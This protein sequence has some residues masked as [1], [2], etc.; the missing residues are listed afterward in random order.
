MKGLNADD[1]AN[2]T[3]VEA[4]ETITPAEVVET[5][6]VVTPPAEVVTT[7]VEVVAPTD[8]TKEK[9]FFE[10]LQEKEVTPPEMVVAPDVKVKELESLLEKANSK[11]KSYEESPIGK[12]AEMVNGEYD[13]TKVDIRKIAKD[14]AGEDYSKYDIKDLIKIEIKK[15][16]PNISDEKLEEGVEARFNKLDDWEIDG[17]KEKIAEKLSA[18]QTPSEV[19][20]QLQKIQQ[21]QLDASKVNPQEYMN[22]VV[23]KGLKEISDKF[24]AYGEQ[25]VGQEFNGYKATK[26]DADAI[27]SLFE[28]DSKNYDVDKG[29]LNN[30]KIV[31]YDKYA[32]AREQAGYERGLK[33]ATNSNP[34]ITDGN[35]VIVSRDDKKGLAGATADSFREA[36]TEQ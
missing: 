10:K 9:T 33:E 36:T 5:T 13:L 34:N 26:E 35:A 14:M 28:N 23:S 18:S 12:L 2:A 8:A 25:I 22:D 15:E 29:Y 16:Y 17:V 1:F 7:P 3:T 32:A 30:F 11:I 21:D 31:T 4:D 27:N 6:E 20:K 24:K 19:F